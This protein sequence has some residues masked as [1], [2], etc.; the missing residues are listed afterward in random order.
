MGPWLR[1]E[2]V[3]ADGGY[4]SKLI[5]WVSLLCQWVL[6]IVN[7]MGRGSSSCRTLGGRTNLLLAVKL[8]AF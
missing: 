2:H 6:E 1:M 8:S 4:A 3:W 5:A 7:T